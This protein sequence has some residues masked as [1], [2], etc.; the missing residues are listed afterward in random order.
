[1][2]KFFVMTCS[3]ALA[4]VIALVIVFAMAG[5]YDGVVDAMLGEG[6]MIPCPDD[7]EA[8]WTQHVSPDIEEL[9]I[10]VLACRNAEEKANG[11]TFSWVDG[12]LFGV[13]FHEDGKTTGS[14]TMFAGERLWLVADDSAKYPHSTQW[15]EDGVVTYETVQR[16][17]TT[18]FTMRYEDGGLRYV[19]ATQQDESLPKNLED[20]SVNFERLNSEINVGEFRT[21]YENGKPKDV[22]AYSRGR[23]HGNWICADETGEY[24]VHAEFSNG[25]LISRTGDT[26]AEQLKDRCKVSVGCGTVAAEPLPASGDGDEEAS[27]QFVS[28][29]AKWP[30]PGCGAAALD[31]AET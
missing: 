19:G 21:Y 10:D 9:V 13:A 18:H 8:M 20:G 23:Q 29:N 15:S 4:L 11:P 7:S 24:E 16:G 2:K 12:Q 6:V 31:Q 3:F 17:S 1:M 22:G 26:E 5:V 28:D 25:R 30:S 27:E 14:R